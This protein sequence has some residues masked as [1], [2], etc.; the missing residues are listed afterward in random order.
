MLL[1]FSQDV[2]IVCLGLILGAVV[3]LGILLAHK[4]SEQLG[5]PPPLPW[6]D[7]D[8]ESADDESADWWKDWEQ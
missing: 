5:P 4:L 6:V 1:A 3:H 7:S 8:D 2:A